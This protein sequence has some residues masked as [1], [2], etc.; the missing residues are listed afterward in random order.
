MGVGRLARLWK[1][2]AISAPP[3]EILNHACGVVSFAFFSHEGSKIR[4]FRPGVRF[5]YRTVPVHPAAM[6]LY[7]FHR[8]GRERSRFNRKGRNGTQRFPQRTH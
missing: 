1:F 2:F 4:R 5:L 6:I 7:Y 3:R 8:R